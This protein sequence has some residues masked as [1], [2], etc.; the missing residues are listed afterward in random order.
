MILICECCNQPIE[1]TA[2][3]KVVHKGG[4]TSSEA[5]NDSKFAPDTDIQKLPDGRMDVKNAAKYLGYHPG[6]LDNWRV[7]G[8]GPNFQKIGG[9]VFYTLEALDAWMTQSGEC[10]STAQARFNKNSI[11]GPRYASI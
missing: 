6:T 8:V 1:H 2:D 9:K 10:K 11:K 3:I 7:T 5:F 4:C